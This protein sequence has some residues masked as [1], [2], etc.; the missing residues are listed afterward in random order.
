[1]TVGF[2]MDLDEESK[3][4]GYMELQPTTGPEISMPVTM[5][6]ENDMGTPFSNQ[7]EAVCFGCGAA[8][9]DPF[10]M[11]VQPDLKWHGRCLK[12][13]KCERGLSDQ[14]SCFVRNGKPYCRE[15]YCKYVWVCVN[16][17][18]VFFEP[19]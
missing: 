19:S 18:F 15:D 13:H 9:Y 3:N 1:M 5:T 12:C 10:I 2:G 8:I 6:A 17:K 11:H 14:T 4:I 7:E 16:L